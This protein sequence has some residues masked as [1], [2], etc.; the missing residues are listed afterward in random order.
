M[1]YRLGLQQIH[2]R[3]E[4]D[5]QLPPVP[6]NRDK[7]QQAVL[8]LVTNACEA[9]PEGGTLT[10]APA[11]TDS[12]VVELLIGDTGPGIPEEV[13]DKI[14]EPFISTKTRGENL[15]LGLFVTRGNVQRHG[16]QITFETQIGKGTDFKISLPLQTPPGEKTS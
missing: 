15:G 12:Q 9:M 7:I 1:D 13:R 14:F 6:V 2:M 5:P 3:L 10:P 11:S 4:L 16:G 8:C